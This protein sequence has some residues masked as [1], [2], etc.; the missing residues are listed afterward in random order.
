MR[1]RSGHWIKTFPGITSEASNPFL[2]A[3]NPVFTP[4]SPNSSEFGVFYAFLGPEINLFTPK[5]GALIGGLLEGSSQVHQ[6]RCKPLIFIQ[7]HQNF[8]NSVTQHQVII[9][10]PN[11][12]NFYNN[13]LPSIFTQR[14][15]PAFENSTTLFTNHFGRN[16]RRYLYHSIARSNHQSGQRQLYQHLPRHRCSR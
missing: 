5:L 12:C 15:P 7:L 8:R 13:I 4:F 11:Y 1:R 2:S 3:T 10:N 6:K 14:V 16:F 9:S